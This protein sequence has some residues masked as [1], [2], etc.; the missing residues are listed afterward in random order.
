MEQH[1][2]SMIWRIIGLKENQSLTT[3]EQQ[4][5]IVEILSQMKKDVQEFTKAEFKKQCINV[6]QTCLETI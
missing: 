5:K 2:M 3:K 1:Y 4:E 6:I